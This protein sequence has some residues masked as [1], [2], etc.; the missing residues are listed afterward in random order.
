VVFIQFL[1]L[2]FQYIK[3][4]QELNIDYKKHEYNLCSIKF[5]G[6][7]YFIRT[8][9]IAVLE[10]HLALVE[11]DLY[12]EIARPEEDVNGLINQLNRVNSIAN[13]MNVQKDFFEINFTCKRDDINN[14]LFWRLSELWFCFQHVS[15]VM[16]SKKGKFNFQNRLMWNKITDIVSCFVL[17]KGVE[18]DVVW[19]GKSDGLTFPYTF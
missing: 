11:G 16:V 2:I 1:A 7:H 12:V 5:S 8:N 19:I 4:M 10:S 14:D 18:E 6:D 9:L 15:F 17:F 3:I 13:S